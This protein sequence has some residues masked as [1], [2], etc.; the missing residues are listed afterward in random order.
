MTLLAPPPP[1]YFPLPFSL[2][3]FISTNDHRNC[4][5]LEFSQFE[6]D[7]VGETQSVHRPGGSAG[8][9]AAA[10]LQILEAFTSRTW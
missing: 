2:S 7:L 9:R 6:T 5:L 8:P 1:V 10:D 4:E 3:N